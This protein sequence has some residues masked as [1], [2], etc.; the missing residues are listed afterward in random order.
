M[1]SVRIGVAG[2]RIVTGLGVTAAALVGLSL[3]TQWVLWKGGG[4]DRR[5]ARLFSLDSEGNLPTWFSGTLL[6]AAAALLA[7]IALRDLRTRAPGG[8][9][10]AGLAVLFLWIA[11]DESAAVHEL[12][13]RPLRDRLGTAGE[14]A[15]RFT[16]VL[17]AGALLAVLAAAYARF[18][19][20]LP[21]PTRVGIVVAAAVYVGGGLGV[22]L[23]GASWSG[24]RGIRSFEYAC[25]VAAEEGL[26]MAGC[27]LLLRTLLRH[28]AAASAH[29]EVVFGGDDPPPGDGA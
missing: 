22:E 13:I 6:L 16:W 17:P 20:R 23:W 28:L 24:E 14:G 25:I 26:E 27:I 9:W 19:L 29:V 8:R 15:L 11:I 3:A 12:S 18:L 2:S 7:V 4:M 1:E 5:V 21:R 10:W